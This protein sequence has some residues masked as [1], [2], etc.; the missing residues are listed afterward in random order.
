M[1]EYKLLLVA[2]LI[3]ANSQ[4]EYT[5]TTDPVRQPGTDRVYVAASET[6]SHVFAFCNI[7][8]VGSPV[9]MVWKL[10]RC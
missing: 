6:D 4:A 1:K 5:I 3:L 9:N 10:I 2:F 8:Q 7:S